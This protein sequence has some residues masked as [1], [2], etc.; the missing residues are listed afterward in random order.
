ML[1]CFALLLLLAGPLCGQDFFPL[2]DVRAGQ[3]ATGRTVFSGT[4]VEEFDVEILG[5]LENYAGPKSSII[6]GR[7]VGG[8]LEE[9]GVLAGMSGSPVYIEGRLA[10][11]V[12]FA[13]AFAKAPLAGIRPIGEMVAGLQAGGAAASAVAVDTL[14]DWRA[15]AGLPRSRPEPR[16]DRRSN[17]QPIAT[18]VSLSGFTE[19]ALEV[20]GDQLE[21]LGLRPLQG[22][23]GGLRDDPGGRIEPGS[24]ISVGL[25][26]GDMSVS[27]SG[28]VTHVDGNRILAFGH[29]LL[30]SGSTAMPL[31][32][33]SVMTLVPNL[34]ASFKLSG[35]GALIG[36]ISLDKQTGIAGELGGGPA[37]VPCTIRIRPGD[38]AAAEYALEMVRDAQLAPLLLQ[39]ALFSAI[40]V[41]ERATGPLTLRVRGGVS[42]KN[43][44][45]RLV[46][47]DIYTGTGGVG[48]SAAL[49]TAVPLAYLLQIGHPGIEIDAVDL[50]VDT[51][52]ADEYTD[53]VRAW[54][55]KTQV[56][57]G[58]TVEIRFAAKGPDGRETVRTVP[59]EVPVSMPAGLVQV[60]VGD[61]LSINM[62]EL[63]GL[64]AGR[65]VRDARATIRFLNS[66]RGSDQAYLRVWQRKQSLWLHSDKLPAPPA[67]VRAILATSSGRGAGAVVEPLSTLADHRIGGFEGVVRGRLNLRFVVT[68]S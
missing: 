45:P 26:R 31:M 53:L 51:V 40:D 3:R 32:R 12:A 63:R 22:A 54:L 36:T 58:E 33:A 52:Q 65:R 25:I 17:F 5:V 28:T 24:M 18:P 13:Y 30:S 61:A 16:W 4:T 9:T 44:L 68:G 64:L 48:Q 67:S 57:P 43:G 1:R 35:I 38:G 49:S 6:F 19:R 47:D 56:R 11:A 55:S 15:L 41:S 7:L 2:E 27:A 66:L 8:P 46:L 10:G 59:Y 34:N 60:T 23:G 37:M 50:E 42:F 62:M 39:M 14:E 21:R 20:F 29:R